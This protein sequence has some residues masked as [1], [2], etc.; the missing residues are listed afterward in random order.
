MNRSTLLRDLRPVLDGQPRIK[1]ALA[2]FD[3]TLSRWHH[4]LAG[5]IP[6]L[7][8]PQPRQLTVAVTAACNLRCMGCRYGRD[9]MVGERLSL[10]MMRDLLDDAREAG[11]NRVR[12]YGGEPL[13]HP[14]L[15][16]IVRYSTGLGM[17]T[18]LTTN[19]VLLGQRIEELYEAGMRWCTI[20][21]YG[22]GDKYDGY[23]QRDGQF[24]RL[25]TSLEQVRERYGSAVEMQLN[26]VLIRPTCN[27]AAVREAWE[28]AQRFELFFHLDLYGYSM[29]F[30][31]DG[32]ENELRFSEAD[33][34]TV[35]AVGD[36]LERLKQAHPQR[37]PQSM[38][39]VRSVPDW[40]LKGPDMRIPC[41]AYQLIWVG[42]D[43]TVQL[44]DVTFKLGNLKERRLRDM[45]FG[46]THRSACR[47][48]FQLKCPNCTCKSDSRIRKH[49]ASV[50]Q[51]GS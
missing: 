23:T 16:E 12:L 41:D 20:G 36:E 4:S 44:C 17:D 15:P 19:A 38:T 26:F 9:F 42:A 6:A 39:L 46:E 18:Y 1:S 34:P 37:F 21:F 27:L 35:Q 32:P 25:C 10:P 2:R 14:D 43:G 50:R 47:D 48:A 45:L 30:F 3:T 40:L 8:H 49:A 11:I 31:T 13:L 33:R 7:I 28:F 29:P 5:T 22:I 51:Y 24:E